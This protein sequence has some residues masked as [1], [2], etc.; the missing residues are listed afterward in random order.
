MWKPVPFISKKK[1]QVVMTVMREIKTYTRKENIQKKNKL[2]MS[3]VHMHPLLPLE[4]PLG[5]RMKHDA[6]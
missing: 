2:Y 4:F 5:A 3:L 6:A 1:G